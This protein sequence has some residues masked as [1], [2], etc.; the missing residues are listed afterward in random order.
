MA[1]LSCGTRLGRE[2]SVRPCRLMVYWSNIGTWSM[3][4]TPAQGLGVNHRHLVYESNPCPWS[5]SYIQAQ[6][7]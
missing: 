7:S 2:G 5:I 1:V 6:G 4:Q 3:G